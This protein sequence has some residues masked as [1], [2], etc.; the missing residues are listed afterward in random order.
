[1]SGSLT[2]LGEMTFQLNVPKIILDFENQAQM[3]LSQITM[4]VK[5]KRVMVCG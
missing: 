2:T 3:V 4:T 1:M 5:V